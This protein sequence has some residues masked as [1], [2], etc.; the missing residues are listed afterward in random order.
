M[1]LSAKVGGLGKQ[2]LGLGKVLGPL[3]ILED[4]LTF[5]MGGDSYTGDLLLAIFPRETVEYIRNLVPDLVA[6]WR[7]LPIF[8][9]G[10]GN[11]ILGSLSELA[12]GISDAF[13]S[14]WNAVTGGKSPVDAVKLVEQA[15]ATERQELMDKYD[16]I[17]TVRR[18]REMSERATAASTAADKALAAAKKAAAEA[19][20]GERAAAAIALKAAQA[21]AALL[22]K[23]ALDAQMQAAAADAAKTQ[24]DANEKTKVATEKRNAANASRGTRT[25]AFDAEIADKAEREAAAAQRL[26][27]EANKKA[28]EVTSKITGEKAATAKAEARGAKGPA[29]AKLEAMKAAKD[30]EAETN[31]A[32]KR[33]AQATDAAA[34][35]RTGQEKAAAKLAE[36]EK[37]AAA[38]RDKP[39]TGAA[40]EKAKEA[41]VLV[42]E[43]KVDAAQLAL[44]TA[45]AEAEASKAILEMQKET[46]KVS[47]EATE[48]LKKAALLTST[49][50]A[51]KNKAADAATEEHRI[52]GERVKQT[53]DVLGAAVATEKGTPAL[54]A[55][56]NAKRT[57]ESA[58]LAA[59]QRAEV[60]KRNAGHR[61]T[62]EELRADYER[63]KLGAPVPAAPGWGTW[64]DEKTALALAELAKG[65]AKSNELTMIAGPPLPPAPPQIIE[66]TTTV[67]TVINVT[68]PP[69]TPETLANDVGKAIEKPSLRATQAALGGRK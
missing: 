34:K 26:A 46:L 28:A 67:A 55:A 27:A 60:D 4:I 56:A 58:K 35:T 30:S 38:I 49:E 20:A 64:K 57:E 12:A 16:R 43:K 22:R 62:S 23:E 18:T 39:V 31:A 66:K 69:G 10:L 11:E 7:T 50:K 47:I 40:A 53:T 65:V 1:M 51:D 54:Q 2:L 45:A 3:L 29:T 14:M 41:A 32:G 21:K 48:T 36:A 61:K 5:F 8:F 15:R 9:E 37:A 63:S 33:V 25:E 52:A 44:D 59:E 68:V 6:D 24:G 13:T 17:A 42:A 19:P